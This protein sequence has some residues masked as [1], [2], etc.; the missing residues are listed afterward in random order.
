MAYLTQ[1]FH[2][3]YIGTAENI[4][5]PLPVPRWQPFHVSGYDFGLQVAFPVQNFH[6]C[7]NENN[8]DMLVH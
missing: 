4:L 2:T 1:I 5:W 7:H 3:Y 8:V 6:R